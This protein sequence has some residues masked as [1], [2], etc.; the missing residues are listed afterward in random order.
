MQSGAIKSRCHIFRNRF[1]INEKAKS[2]AKLC[3]KEDKVE[4][5]KEKK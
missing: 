2:C 1:G 4:K 5:K 3:K